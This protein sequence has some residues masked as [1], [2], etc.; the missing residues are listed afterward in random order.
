M[1]PPEA[2]RSRCRP[3]ACHMSRLTRAT[4]LPLAFILAFA[5]A[6]A[7]TLPHPSRAVY[8]HKMEIAWP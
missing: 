5:S 6:A 7:Q 1:E 8:E 3:F 2:S 4:S